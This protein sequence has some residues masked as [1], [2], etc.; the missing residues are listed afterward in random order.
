[1]KWRWPSRLGSVRVPPAVD[2]LAAG[3][4]AV[5]GALFL[6]SWFA[7]VRP[8]NGWFVLDLA[9]IWFWTLV[10]SAACVSVGRVVVDRLLPAPDRTVLETLALSFPVGVV[11]FVLGMTAGGFAH[12]F[13]RPFAVAWPALMLIATARP[14]VEWL[15]GQATP[16]GHVALRGL[17]LVLTMLGVCLVLLLYLG[18]LSPQAV[19]YDAGWVHMVISQDYAR[20]GRIVAFPGDQV[21]NLP[22]LG[23]MLCTWAF[24]VPGLDLPQLRWMMALHLEFSVFLWTLVTIAA[25]ARWFAEREVGA[26]WTALMLFPGI[27]V[28]DS[29][30]GGAGDHFGALFAAPLLIATAKTLRRFDRRAAVLAGIIAGGAIMAKLQAFYVLMPLAVWALARAGRLV[31]RRSRGAVDAPEPRA[32]AIAFACTAGVAAALLLPHLASNV[33]FFRNPMYPLMQDVFTHSTPTVRDAPFL[34]RNVLAD[35]GSQP[36]AALGQ[37]LAHAFAMTFSFSFIPHYSF[38]NEMPVF[39]SVFTLALPLLVPIGRA[40]RVWLGAALVLGMVFTWAMSYWV[41]RN[42]QAFL[43]VMAAVTAAILIRA[44]ELGWLA[45]AGVVVLLAVQLAWAV[46]WYFQGSDRLIGAINLFKASTEGHAREIL[47]TYRGQYVALGESLPRDAV[48]MLHNQRRMLG[49][50]RPVILDWMGFQTIIDYQPFKTPR[51]LYDRLREIGVTHVV[52]SQGDEEA[53]TMQA[54]IIFDVFAQVY[55]RNRQQFSK[56]TVAAMP[57]PPPPAEDVYKVVTVGVRGYPDGLYDVD[58]LFRNDQLPPS[59]RKQG[60]PL[61]ISPS[62]AALLDDARVVLMAGDAAPD[63]ETRA[64]LARDFHDVPAGGGL[65]LLLRN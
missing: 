26:T 35:W 6:L 7:R 41:D 15:R 2:S 39:G 64:R 40:R 62:P 13:N 59:Y 43:P 28:Y 8:L 27:F 60:A 49:I 42:L 51:D 37:R 16:P 10:L 3:A 61:E 14:T 55:G 19:N 52:W 63:A 54:E 20:E 56:L 12:L 11:V 9:V 38:V 46:P 21:K 33:V 34:V 58:A 17:P 1:M 30:L 50:D 47:R 25:V 32:I 36:P 48:V 22:H 24:I 57:S 44:W 5:V 31:V 23:P 65:R 45:R 29:N 4:I 53:A 18:A